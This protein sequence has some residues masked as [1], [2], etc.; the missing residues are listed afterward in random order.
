MEILHLRDG[1]VRELTFGE[2]P[3]EPTTDRND[4]PEAS[5]S[6]R[7]T[8]PVISCSRCR[9]ARSVASLARMSP[10]A[11][12]SLKRFASFDRSP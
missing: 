7:S 4:E 5:K 9:Q 11:H 3:E 1:Q 2:M 8:F 12:P 6:G 10:L